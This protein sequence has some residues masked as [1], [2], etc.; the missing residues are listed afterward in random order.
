MWGV[1]NFT[2]SRSYSQFYR[3]LIY[4]L[5]L[6]IKIWIYKL[7]HILFAFGWESN[8]LRHDHVFRSS[9]YTLQFSNIHRLRDSISTLLSILFFSWLLL[10]Q[11]SRFVNQR[12]CNQIWTPFIEEYDNVDGD[13][14]V[15]YNKF[16]NFSRR[17]ET[18]LKHGTHYNVVD[19]YGM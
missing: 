7:R 10:L 13:D 3:H 1:R 16:G 9:W 5:N 12:V 17:N 4:I 6:Y 2:R 8:D 19:V 14:L 11:W 15:T 18:G